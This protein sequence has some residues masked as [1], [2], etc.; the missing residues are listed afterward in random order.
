MD[1]A[2]ILFSRVLDTRGSQLPLIRLH[3]EIE[4]VSGSRLLFTSV[5]LNFSIEHK[6]NSIVHINTFIVFFN[7]APYPSQIA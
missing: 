3:E 4:L 6:N 1:P 2:T 5:K 7:H